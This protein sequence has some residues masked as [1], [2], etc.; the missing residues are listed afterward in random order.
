MDASTPTRCGP[1]PSKRHELLLDVVGAQTRDA[2]DL[3]RP[4]KAFDGQDIAARERPGRD[5]HSGA[6]AA[7]CVAFPS[8]V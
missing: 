2:F 4:L 1:F 3:A 7:Q 6:A 8:L 5:G